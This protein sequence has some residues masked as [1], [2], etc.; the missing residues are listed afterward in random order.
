[1]SYLKMHILL[2]QKYSITVAKTSEPWDVLVHTA[3]G[4]FEH[5]SLWTGKGSRR[6]VYLS[7]YIPEVPIVTSNP[8]SQPLRIIFKASLEKKYFMI[9][10]K[11]GGGVTIRDDGLHVTSESLLIN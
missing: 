5:C 10:S 2:I 9:G 11:S 3:T 1:M 8:L 7:T 4:P 6:K